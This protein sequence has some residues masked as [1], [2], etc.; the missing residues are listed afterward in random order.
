MKVLKYIAQTRRTRNM[1][2]R[3]HA[4]TLPDKPKP[5]DL[6]APDYQYCLEVWDTG[7]RQFFDAGSNGYL[8]Y[9]PDGMDPKVLRVI[10]KKYGMRAEYWKE[11]H[12]M[13]VYRKNAAF[14]R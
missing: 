14:D 13:W 3:D 1:G 6:T 9:M 12:Q 10:A 5:T 11:R 7:A 4:M 8:I 2:D